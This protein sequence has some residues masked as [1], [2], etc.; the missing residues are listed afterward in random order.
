[1]FIDHSVAIDNDVGLRIGDSYDWDQWSYRDRMTVTNSVLYNNDDN[2]WNF[3]YT[4]EAPLEGALNISNSMTNDPDFD[5]L[6]GNIAAV[7]QFDP[8]Y[9][10]LPGSPGAARGMGRPAVLQAHL[11]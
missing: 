6:A 4:L 8:S 11:P 3:V 1:M 10:L 5:A 2:V 9:F 7:P